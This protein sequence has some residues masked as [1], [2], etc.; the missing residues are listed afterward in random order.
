VTDGDVRRVV[1]SSGAA[2]SSAVRVHRWGRFGRLLRGPSRFADRCSRLTQR[3]QRRSETR[4]AFFL[5][6]VMAWMYLGYACLHAGIRRRFPR[7]A[8]FLSVLCLGVL[9]LWVLTRWAA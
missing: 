8:G 5:L 2:P 1:V 7:G 4:T 9:G 3:L 6:V